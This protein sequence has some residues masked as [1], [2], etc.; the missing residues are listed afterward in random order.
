MVDDTFR[1]EED[2]FSVGMYT[3]KCSFFS[4]FLKT[5]LQREHGTFSIKES[6]GVFPNMTK[7]VQYSF[8]FEAVRRG[9]R[10]FTL[11]RPRMGSVM[12]PG[13]FLNLIYI[14]LGFLPASVALFRGQRWNGL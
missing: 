14:D 6:F 7:T 13:R 5:S 11:S 9:T 4:F 1:R 3:R 12:R 10:A 8:A 2:R